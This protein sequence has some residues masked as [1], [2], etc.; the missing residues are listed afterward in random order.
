MAKY[1]ISDLHGEYEMFMA[2]LDKINFSDKD[3]LYILGD[4]LDRGKRPLDIVDYIVGKSNITWI[5]GNHDNMFCEY[6]DNNNSMLWFMNGGY[7][8]YEQLM[9]SRNEGYITSLYNYIKKLST[10]KIVDNYVLVHAGALSP[11]YENETI[12]E[13][14]ES[15]SEEFLLWD[16]S[17][18]G[19]KFNSGKYTLICGHTAT[20]LLSNGDNIVF[21]KDKNKIFIDCGVMLRDGQL[22]CLRLDDLKEFYVTKEDVKND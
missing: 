11:T 3:E 7:T 22:G 19:T 10:Y 16:R 6:V 1:V 9:L 4:I 13:H 2:M 15:L 14:M 17:H 18:I 12:E 20:R 21:D 5:K 8:T